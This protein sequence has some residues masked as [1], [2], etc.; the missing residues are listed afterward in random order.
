MF[1]KVKSVRPCG[2]LQL[3]VWFEDGETRH[4][5]VRPLLKKW[6]A[7]RA[8]E[9]E[10]LFAS[11]EVVGRGYGIAWNDE[12]DLAC[13]ELYF[14]GSEVDVIEAGKETIIAE[15]IRA[16]EIAGLTQSGLEA[17]SG[18]SQPVIA[19]LERGET[20]PQIDTLLKVLAPLGKTLAVIDLPP[21][22]EVA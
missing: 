9:D 8:L 15:V 12:I 18:V 4:Y 5:D 2:R 14:G 11:V 1:H 20:S 3:L 7:F 13:D 10:C 16:R 22:G 17:I 21:F 19:R 6:E